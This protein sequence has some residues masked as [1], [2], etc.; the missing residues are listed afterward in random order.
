M[1]Q[2]NRFPKNIF[3]VWFQGQKNLTDP[4]FRENVK[5]WKILNPDWNHHLLSDSDLRE[6]CRLFSEDCLQV[7]DSLSIM[8]MKIDLARYVVVYLYGGIYVDMDMYAMRSLKFSNYVN[9]ITRLYERGDHVIGFSEL[10][11][12]NRLE[13]WVNGSYNNSIMMCN[14][15]NPTMRS[16]IEFVLQR[17]KK[18]K[19]SRYLTKEII[20]NLTTGPRSFS[21]FFQNPKNLRLT[22]VVKIPNTV[23]EPCDIGGNCDIF[24][25]TISI[26]KFELSWLSNTH[27][28]LA[29]F[30]YKYLRNLPSIILVV[31]VILFLKR[32][33]SNKFK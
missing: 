2:Q 31:L 32:F 13:K 18:Y 28:Q 8:H 4:K 10:H 1:N 19:D 30:Y 14:P 16:F 7:Y 25:E 9:Q 3:Q 24:P 23:F 17:C 29:K 26:H 15:R 22:K 27:K 33:L 6:A 21:N 12:L 11:F 20:V 5:N